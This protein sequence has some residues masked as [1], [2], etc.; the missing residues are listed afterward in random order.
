MRQKN[1]IARKTVTYVESI[2]TSSEIRPAPVSPAVSEAGSASSRR[3]ADLP[4]ERRSLA[5]LA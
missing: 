2:S 5:D 1:G 3:A 4:G